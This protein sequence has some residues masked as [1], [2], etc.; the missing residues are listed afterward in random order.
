M[1]GMFAMILSAV[2]TWT[3]QSKSSVQ[4]SGELP[5]GV[6]AEYDC[7]YQKGT[8][9][10]GDVATLALTGIAGIEVQQIDYYLRSN[11][12]SGA[13]TI[14]VTADGTL[15][16]TKSGSLRDWCGT[17]D[18]DNYHAVMAWQGSRLISESLV[19][20]LGGSTN[21]L[22]I[23]RF[24]ITYLPAPPEP[25]AP[26]YTVTLTDGN[27]LYATL[28]ESSGGAGVLLPALPNRAYWRFVGWSERDLGTIDEQ[29]SLHYAGNRFYPTG[30]DSLWAVYQ[31][32]EMQGEK[33]FVEELIS[34]V[35]MYVNRGLNVALRGVPAD[36]RMTSAAVDAYDDNQHYQITFVGTDT[37]YIS[38]VPTGTPIGYSVASRT[39]AAQASPWLVY[40]SGDQT[41]FYTVI[42]GK[43]YVL[44]LNVY[45]TQTRDNYAGLLQANPGVSPMGLQDTMMPT[46]LYAFTTH[47][48]WALGIDE[49]QEA[50]SAERI[51]R[52]GNYEIH[53]QNGHK[54]LY[55][56]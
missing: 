28:T 46:E 17:Y 20:Q 6:T 25:P 14:T 15:L 32:A 37:A 27:Q 11:K 30:N 43:N 53:I 41:I 40:H 21:S 51:I 26:T 48:E 1:N 50:A 38:H 23:E 49:T 12:S 22:Y 5:A 47:P 8:V 7:T 31:Y 35:Y 45:D 44:W 10:A 55:L 56:R 3:V 9:R 18:A 33:P 36:G 34:G 29:P 39:M 13:G 24:V 42:G 2:M 16:A 19:L 54:K 4:G 52:F